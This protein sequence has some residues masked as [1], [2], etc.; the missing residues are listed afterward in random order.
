ML[1]CIGIS[2][3]LSL[4]STVRKVPSSIYNEGSNCR[5][6]PVIQD[7][8]PSARAAAAAAVGLCAVS[9]TA[10]TLNNCRLRGSVVR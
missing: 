3:H 7:Q 9:R 10:L 1:L 8:Q 5:D 6:K 2:A 4:C